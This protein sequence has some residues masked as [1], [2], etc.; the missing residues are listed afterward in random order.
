MEFDINHPL[1]WMERQVELEAISQ[2]GVKRTIL[3]S[4]ASIY[5]EDKL[6]RL[7]E[8]PL[9]VYPSLPTK[10]MQHIRMIGPDADEIDPDQF[11]KVL[12]DVS[13]DDPALMELEAE[14]QKQPDESLPPHPFEVAFKLAGG[15]IPEPAEGMNWTMHH[16]YEGRFPFEGKTASFNAPEWSFHQTQT[17]G[18]VWV[19]PSMESLW[20]DFGAI[21]K[22][23]RARA[24]VRFGYDPDRYFSAGEHDDETG[25]DV[26]RLARLFPRS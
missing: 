20:R 24:W 5:A 15:S 1:R 4:C 16:L 7:A 26:A 6:V 22:T 3:T 10:Y 25:F 23:L 18:L 9:L 13:T 2:E 21:V 14:D 11:L 19:H 12:G 8:R 17:A